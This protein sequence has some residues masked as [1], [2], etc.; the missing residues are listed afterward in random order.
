[1]MSSITMSYA[2]WPQVLLGCQPWLL[3]RSHH[4]PRGESSVLLARLPDPIDVSIVS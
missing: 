3:I 2:Y 4:C 1:M